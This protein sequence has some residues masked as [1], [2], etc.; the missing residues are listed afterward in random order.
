MNEKGS[1]ALNKESQ[2]WNERKRKSEREKEGDFDFTLAKT[3][4]LIDI[5]YPSD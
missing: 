4:K 5:D 1:N 3:A 2:R